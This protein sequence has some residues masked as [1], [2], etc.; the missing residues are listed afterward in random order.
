[1]LPSTSAIVLDVITRLD[2]HMGI[3][4]V[5]ISGVVGDTCAVSYTTW[6]FFLLN[7]GLATS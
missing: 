5:V 6:S 4:M 3:I 7:Q 2:G 1:M